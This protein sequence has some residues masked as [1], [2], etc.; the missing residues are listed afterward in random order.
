MQRRAYLAELEMAEQEK[1]TTFS[2]CKV[3]FSFFKP[4]FSP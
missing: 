3:V 2:L 4:D 1:L